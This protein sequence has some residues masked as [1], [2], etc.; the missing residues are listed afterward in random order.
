MPIDEERKEAT[1]LSITVDLQ[2][3]ENTLNNLSLETL[4]TISNLIDD[5]VIEIEDE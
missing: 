2:M 1:I 5:V 3:I 4:Y